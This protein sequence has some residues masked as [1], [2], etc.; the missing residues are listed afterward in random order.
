MRVN[1]L[2]R[3]TLRAQELEHQSKSTYSVTSLSSLLSTGSAERPKKDNYNKLCD[4]QVNCVPIVHSRFQIVNYYL[5]DLLRCNERIVRFYE[6]SILRE[7][8]T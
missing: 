7:I 1:L 6:K 4:R 2:Y 5:R 3:Q 8:V